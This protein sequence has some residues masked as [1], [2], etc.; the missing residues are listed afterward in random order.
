MKKKIL[1]KIS[2]ELFRVHNEPCENATDRVSQGF[3][4]RLV[5]SLAE[6]IK[7]L[8]STYHV[9]LVIGGGN[10]FRGSHE[11]K[12]LKLRQS[13]ADNVG[14]LA[15]VMNGI[16]LQECLQN[17]G[18]R[19]VLLS[20]VTIPKMVDEITQ[21]RIDQALGQDQCIIFAGGTGNPFFTTDTNAVIRALQMGASQ[22]WKATKVDTIYDDDPVKKPESKPIRTITFK[23]AIERNLKIMDQTALTLAHEHGVI[24]RIF[25]LFAPSALLNVAHQADFGS[26]IFS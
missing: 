12:H 18:T 25:N 17:E 26:T 14:M 15:T 5:H 3:D 11:G 7:E 10:F 24:I 19:S 23:E 9:G 13:V 21:Q 20:A 4:Y 16:I 22:V 2:G 6:Q 1:I 8:S